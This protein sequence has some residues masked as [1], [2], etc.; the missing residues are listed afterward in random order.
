MQHGACHLSVLGPEGALLGL[1]RNLRV[2]QRL[3]P[4]ARRAQQRA[5]RC[6]T[7]GHLAGAHD[8]QDGYALAL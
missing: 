6:V 2:R 3:L 5:Q 1:Q 7:A 4:P 8:S